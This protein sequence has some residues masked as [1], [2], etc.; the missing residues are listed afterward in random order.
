MSL[1]IHG[2]VARGVQIFASQNFANV[3][4][5]QRLEQWE[6][7]P[8]ETAFFQRSQRADETANEIL[9]PRAKKLRNET[10]NFIMRFPTSACRYN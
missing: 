7:R 9:K 5:G 3:S 6:Q 2:T 10:K 8:N 4:C 1:Y